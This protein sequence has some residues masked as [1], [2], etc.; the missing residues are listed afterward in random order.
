M[1][2]SKPGLTKPAIP[3]S[4]SIAVRVMAAGSGPRAT[5]RYAGLVVG[6]GSGLVA[7][8]VGL[9]SAW[10]VSAGAVS[11]LPIPVVGLGGKVGF[12]SA[13]AVSVGW[14]GLCLGVQLARAA[15]AAAV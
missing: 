15:P 2:T 13:A 5:A 3:P 8:S 4:V 6:E 9:V 1:I 10:V 11:V 7:V 12:N 14:F